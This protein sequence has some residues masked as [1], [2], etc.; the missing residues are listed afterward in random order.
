M[1]NQYDNIFRRKEEVTL[2][3][4]YN[5]SSDESVNVIDTSESSDKSKRAVGPGKLGSSDKTFNLPNKGIIN[6]KRIE[7]LEKPSPNGRFK[8][9]K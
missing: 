6:Q 8:P 1:M 3:V 7:H 2:K 4:D 9:S 5:T